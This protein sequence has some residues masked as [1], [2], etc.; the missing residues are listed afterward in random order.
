MPYS[1]K[2]M[3]VGINSDH[4]RSYRL[5]KK[6]VAY[7]GVIIFGLIWFLSKINNQT[8]FKKKTKPVQTDLFQF[9]SVF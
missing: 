8:E 9:G 3:S 6:S 1:A 7:L 4:A 2:L 5:V